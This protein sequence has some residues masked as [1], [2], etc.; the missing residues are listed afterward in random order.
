MIFNT[1]VHDRHYKNHGKNWAQDEKELMTAMFLDG[2]TMQEIC[3]RL[4]R[5]GLGVLAKLKDRRLVL[6]V[7]SVGSETYSVTPIYIPAITEALM[8]RSGAETDLSKAKLQGEAYLKHQLPDIQG[9]G[10]KVERAP[11]LKAVDYSS[12]ELREIQHW[13]QNNPQILSTRT[14]EVLGDHQTQPNPK[15][16]TVK[17]I[18]TKTFIRG[19]EASSMSDAEIF[20]QIGKLELEAK[21]LET[22]QNKPHKLLSAIADLNKDIAALVAYVDGREA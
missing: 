5:P 16:T 6:P 19:V 20:K 10:I 7:P 11:W 4:E 12:L 1:K 22:I 2:R 14:K 13:L 17:N 3:D 21:Q 9:A 8:R 15:E 18:E